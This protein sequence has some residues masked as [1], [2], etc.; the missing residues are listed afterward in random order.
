MGCDQIQANPFQANS[1]PSQAKPKMTTTPTDVENFV[2]HLNMIPDYCW[3]SEECL[4]VTL[5]AAMMYAIREA[6][7]PLVMFAKASSPHVDVQ[8]QDQMLRDLDG[9]EFTLIWHVRMPSGLCQPFLTLLKPLIASTISEKIGIPVTRFEWKVF[10]PMIV[11][12]DPAISSPPPDATPVNSTHAMHRHTPTAFTLSSS[13]TATAAK[14]IT[15]PPAP[16]AAAPSPTPPPVE[17]SKR[18]Y[19][20]KKASSSAAADDDSGSDPGFDPAV[21]HKKTKGVPPPFVTV[22]LS[23][24]R[25]KKSSSSS[26]KKQPPTPAA[27]AP[28]V[29]VPPAAAPVV[30]VPP[31]PSTQNTEDER[32][33]LIIDSEDQ[34]DEELFDG[35]DVELSP[36]VARLGPMNSDT[37]CAL[38]PPP[39]LLQSKPPSSSTTGMKKPKNIIIS[40]SGKSPTPTCA[41]TQQIKSAV[42]FTIAPPTQQQQQLTTTTNR[43]ASQISSV[44]MMDVDQVNY[45]SSDDED[46]GG[47][48]ES[49][50]TSLPPPAAARCE[51]CKAHSTDLS[52]CGTCNAQQCRTDRYQCERCNKTWCH[53]LV[54]H[55]QALPPGFGNHQT[56]ICLACTKVQAGPRPP[57]SQPPLPPAIANRLG[58]RPASVPP[59]R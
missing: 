2:I 25:G 43:I 12:V 29:V 52:P 47:G 26:S 7:E 49:D 8:P 21:P 30:V 1:V 24:S 35:I 27:A 37:E 6:I 36:D 4:F 54:C 38:P 11:V 19:K 15:P 16:A 41:A 57:S 3:D 18:Q 48:G 23:S 58:T 17:K 34:N 46:D 33:E 9:F 10:T 42:T 44:S 32:D 20:R 40:E 5:N 31:P 55:R 14:K 50:A 39:L 22:P 51:H 56:N 59:L 28:V 53:S 13:A 45:S